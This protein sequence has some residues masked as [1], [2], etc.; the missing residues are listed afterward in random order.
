[1]QYLGFEKMMKLFVRSLKPGD[2]LFTHSN[3][4]G[5]ITCAIVV[6]VVRLPTKQPQR[7]HAPVFLVHT[8]ITHAFS[9]MP[10]HGKLHF[11]AEESCVYFDEVISAH[12][13][14]ATEIEG[15][16]T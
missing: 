1:M 13:T 8:I 12:G 9:T 11:F 10:R 7:K 6:A 2:A 5:D 14:G 16:R 15:T 3:V 4:N